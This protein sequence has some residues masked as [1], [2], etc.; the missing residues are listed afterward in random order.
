[1]QN[2]FKQ[3]T[4]KSRPTE[5][6][7]LYS[8]MWQKTNI[9]VLRP[10]TICRFQHCFWLIVNGSFPTTHFS[11]K[12][13]SAKN[14]QDSHTYVG[15]K[16]WLSVH[17]FR[18]IRTSKSGPETNIFSIFQRCLRLNCDRFMFKMITNDPCTISKKQ[19]WNPSLTLRNGRTCWSNIKARCSYKIVLV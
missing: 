3:N 12:N 7:L 14:K 11:K 4:K 13:K 1:M 18:Q 10:K 17:A 8:G 19:F 16:T 9:F 2:P 15:L 5:P 6:F